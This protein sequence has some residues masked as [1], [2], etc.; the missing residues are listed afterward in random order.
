M[1]ADESPVEERSKDKFL[2]SGGSDYDILESEHLKIELHD[3]VRVKQRKA[4]WQVNTTR[5]PFSDLPDDAN[6]LK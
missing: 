3:K 6:I 2:Y 5:T 1:K 4:I